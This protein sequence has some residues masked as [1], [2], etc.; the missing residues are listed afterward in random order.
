MKSKKPHKTYE[1]VCFDF[2]KSEFEIQVQQN[3]HSITDCCLQ[4]AQ[5]RPNQIGNWEPSSIHIQKLVLFFLI[6]ILY[7]Y[8]FTYNEMYHW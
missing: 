2:A 1:F 8:H 4:K 5:I 7:R 6:S 3:L